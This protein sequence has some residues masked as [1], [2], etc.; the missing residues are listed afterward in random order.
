MLVAMLYDAWWGVGTW[1]SVGMVVDDAV[2]VGS[3]EGIAG[4]RSVTKKTEKVGKVWV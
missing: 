1:W 4:E 2:E 3:E